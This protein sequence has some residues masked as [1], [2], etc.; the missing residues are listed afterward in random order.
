MLLSFVYRKTLQFGQLSRHIAGGIR[1]ASYYT[2]SS[3]AFQA[4]VL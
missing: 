1:K 2:L 4:I 3:R